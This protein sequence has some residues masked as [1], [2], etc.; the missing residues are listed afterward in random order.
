MVLLCAEELNIAR[1]KCLKLL[2]TTS[3]IA[4]DSISAPSR[5]STKTK[6]GGVKYFGSL[7]KANNLF[8]FDLSS[9]QRMTCFTSIF[10]ALGGPTEIHTGF[11]N[12]VD[13]IFSTDGGMVAENNRVCLLI[14]I[15]SRIDFT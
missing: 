10:G 1:C 2:Q 8:F 4:S 3:C 5:E 12:R 13:D 6:I 11:A 7:S 15:L 9:T 14:G